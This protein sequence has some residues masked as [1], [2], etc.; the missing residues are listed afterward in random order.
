MI[1]KPMHSGI[2]RDVKMVVKC[3]FISSQAYEFLQT[4]LIWNIMKILKIKEKNI[5]EIKGF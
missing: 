5:A 4:E 3:I 2:E 1:R